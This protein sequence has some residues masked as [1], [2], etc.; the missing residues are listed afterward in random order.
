MDSKTTSSI[1]VVAATIIGVLSL[2]LSGPQSAPDGLS[3][4]TQLEAATD[5]LINY[6]YLPMPPVPGFDSQITHICKLGGLQVNS[7]GLH[8]LVPG[9]L[10]DSPDRSWPSIVNPVFNARFAFWGLPGLSS[11]NYFP[12]PDDVRNEDNEAWVS[13]D[14]ILKNTIF[15]Y[16]VV[17]ETIGTFRLM[18]IMSL[19]ARD[20]I[21][22]YVESDT[23]KYSDKYVDWMGR[24]FPH[25]STIRT[26]FKVVLVSGNRAFLPVDVYAIASNATAPA[27]FDLATGLS[28]AES[29]QLLEYLED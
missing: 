3:S 29:Q 13:L 23:E 5:A 4:Q 12:A 25:G 14:P 28:L 11:V 1:V 18:A 6:E 10:T 9:E 21:T 27:T 26:S 24:S 7:A 8:L 2:S 15:T 20:V 16:C 19:M 17:P 22:R